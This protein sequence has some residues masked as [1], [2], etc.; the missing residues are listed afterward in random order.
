MRETYEYKVISFDD[1]GGVF[2]RNSG[3]VD[4]NAMSQNL[5]ALGQLGWH[6]V[7]AY[8]NELGKN[9]LGGAIGGIGLGAN[10]TVDENI[11]IFE[12]VVYKETPEEKQ[13]KKEKEKKE[14]NDAI[15]VELN[16]FKELLELGAISQ[17]DYDKKEKELLSTIVK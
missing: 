6:L 17:E 8:S 7:T 12:R 10:A 3:R 4:T 13:L 11:L 15:M 5:N 9:A 2:N 16:S 1:I 14:K